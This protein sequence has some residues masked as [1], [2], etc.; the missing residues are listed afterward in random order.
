MFSLFSNPL[1]FHDETR[2]IDGLKIYALQELL[3]NSSATETFKDTLRDFFSRPQPNNRICYPSGTPAL[4]IVRTIMKLLQEFPQIP[5]DSV[6][7]NA[8]SGCAT[9]K[10]EIAIEPQNR[11]FK[12]L[13]DCQ[14][15]AQESGLTNA[16]GMPDQ[17]KAA[18]DFGYQC[19]QYFEENL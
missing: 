10:G 1:S 19:F 8:R 12:F 15:R 18:Q 17:V 2:T 13:W 4:K 3:D 14:W 16:W 6:H 7:I 11:K 5:F 9:F